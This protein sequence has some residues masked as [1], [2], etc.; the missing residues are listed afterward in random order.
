MKTPYIIYFLLIAA[1]TISNQPH[2]FGQ[3]F[4][5]KE[6][7]NEIKMSGNY[8]WGEGSDF[9][10]ELAKFSASV[11]LSNQI[12]KDAVGQSVQL[13]EMLKVIETGV[14]LDRLPQ[15]GK[16]KILAWI[17]KDSVLLT[18]ITQRPITQPN[19]PESIS[20]TP[21]V[22]QKEEF[23]PQPSHVPTPVL[24]P[25]KT[26]NSVLQEL[27]VCKT[28]NDVKRVATTKGLVRGEFGGGSKGFSNPENCI[29]A[30]FTTDGKLTALLDTGVNSRT[31]V[32]SGNII[33]KPE[34]YYNSEVYYLWYMQQ[35]KVS[36]KN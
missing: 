32:L 15:Q 19:K 1:G 12:I 36:Q 9:N 31:D 26:D 6:R 24:N 23:I 13:D 18:V 17:V 22:Q 11:E 8:F 21:V 34:Q 28:Y 29:I 20:S 14:H 27:A 4:L 3:D 33:Q 10:E 5:P 25:A 35:M 16:I 30:V 2:L 7:E